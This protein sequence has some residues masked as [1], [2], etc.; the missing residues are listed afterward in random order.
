MEGDEQLANEVIALF[1]EEC[2]KLLADVRAAAEQRDVP[3]LERAAHRLKGCVGDISAPQAFD[4]ARSLER[5]ARAKNLQDA[6][7]ALSRLEA[8]LH[9]LMNELRDFQMKAA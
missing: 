6:G 7:A 9:R 4:A 2:P 8:A 1:L 3:L 5:K